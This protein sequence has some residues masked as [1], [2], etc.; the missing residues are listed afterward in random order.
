[1]KTFTAMLNRF[2]VPPLT[3]IGENSLAAFGI[4]WHDFSK[5]AKLHSTWQSRPT[6]F[7]DGAGQCFADL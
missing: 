1:V 5:L 4:G 3:A 6:K 2:L 7:Y